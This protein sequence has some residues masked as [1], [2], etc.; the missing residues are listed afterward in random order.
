MR[1]PWRHLPSKPPFVLPVDRPYVDVFNRDAKKEYRIERDLLPEPFNGNIDA[2]VVVLLLNPGVDR[3]DFAVNADRDFRKLVVGSLRN[4]SRSRGHWFIGDDGDAPGAK[5]W[6]RA[7]G[8]LA[9]R[10]GYARLARGVLTVEYFPYHSVK[11]S[12]SSLRLPSQ[13]YTFS[14]VRRAI[15]RRAVIVIARG[16]RQWFGAVPQLADHK[17]LFRLR[18][19]QSTFISP[20]NLSGRNGF[21][22]LCDALEQP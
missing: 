9:E 10:V 4:P 8:R 11:Y 2:P 17:P 1:N 22:T 18:S 21:K 3:G 5:W 13:E 19:W 7:T 14:L 16:A 12:H 6:R 15:Q 20:R